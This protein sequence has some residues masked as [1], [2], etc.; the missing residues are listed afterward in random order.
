MYQYS[1]PA[2]HHRFP[3]RRRLSLQ[4]DSA[5][6]QGGPLTARCVT[7]KI[8]D[9]GT[10]TCINNGLSHESNVKLG[11]PFYMAPEVT[12]DHRLHQASDVYAFGVIM[13]ELMMGC[14]VY[15]EKCA[16]HHK[17]TTSTHIFT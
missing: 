17:R 4:V 2:S 5:A 6:L 15:V 10:A 3:G 12:K 9:F 11:T 13:W 8:T 16:S 7:A 14:S 1:R